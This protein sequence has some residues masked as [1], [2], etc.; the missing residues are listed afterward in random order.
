VSVDFYPSQTRIFHGQLHSRHGD[1]SVKL[2]FEP[3]D[4]DGMPTCLSN[5]QVR[6]TASC[7]TKSHLYPSRTNILEWWKI[8][9]IRFFEVLFKGVVSTQF[10]PRTIEIEH[11]PAIVEYSRM[12]LPSLSR[13][14]EIAQFFCSPYRVELTSWHFCR[15]QLR[16][17]DDD[18]IKWK[19]NKEHR[20]SC[21]NGACVRVVLKG[22]PRCFN[23]NEWLLGWFSQMEGRIPNAHDLRPP[24]LK[25]LE[26]RTSVLDWLW[27][28]IICYSCE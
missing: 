18:S 16:S 2:N 10:G 1:V 9:E 25:C 24:G 14:C 8:D 19:K 7:R 27:F 17:Q 13:G 15:T 6:V 12:Q 26:G 21:L 11:P 20:I 4:D 23:L 3:Q 28:I 22:R 5:S